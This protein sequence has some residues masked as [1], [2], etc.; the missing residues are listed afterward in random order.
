MEELV[1]WSK[2][3]Q[4]IENDGK[5]CLTPVR[6]RQDGKKEPGAA[7]RVPT[8]ISAGTQ[9]Q[10]VGLDAERL[11]HAQRHTHTCTHTH[12]DT[13][14][15]STQACTFR[16]GLLRGLEAGALQ[17]QAHTVLSFW[18]LNATLH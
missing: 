17:R 10:R 11:T 18:P 15:R 1:T 12:T 2:E 16:A 9:A 7:L 3:T 13:R 4:N 8:S 5:G 14:T 6:A